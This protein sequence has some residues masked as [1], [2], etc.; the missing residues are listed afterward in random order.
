MADLGKNSTKIT[1]AAIGIVTLIVTAV[2]APALTRAGSSA[3]DQ[4][5][6]LQ[7]LA[8]LEECTS[9]LKDVP[10]TVAEVKAMLRAVQEGLRRV[11]EKQDNQ[12]RT[13]K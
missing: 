4:A 12:G 1:L 2:L 13:S 10:E 11:E 6:I 5:A 7:R 3:A 9:R 8:R